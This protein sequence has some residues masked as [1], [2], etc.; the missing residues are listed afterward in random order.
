M[1]EP[2]GK[3]IPILS[4]GHQL[5]TFFFLSQKF[6]DTFDEGAIKKVHWKE[7]NK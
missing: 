3:T 7:R 5:Q 1:N 4:P 6:E 2:K